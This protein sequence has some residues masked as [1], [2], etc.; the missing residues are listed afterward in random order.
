MQYRKKQKWKIK[1][2][3][4]I[5]SHIPNLSARRGTRKDGR[6]AIQKG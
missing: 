5:K 1:K 2:E 3:S 4:R 6:K